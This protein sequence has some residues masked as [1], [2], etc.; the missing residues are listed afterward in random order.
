MK[1]KLIKYSPYVLNLILIIMMGYF[2]F[3]D[4]NNINYEGLTYFKLY[5]V[6]YGKFVLVGLYLVLVVLLEVFKKKQISTLHFI[7]NLSLIFIFI[8]A[9]FRLNN[10]LYLALFELLIPIVLLWLHT[11][12]IKSWW[13]LSKTAHVLEKVSKKLTKNFVLNITSTHVIILKFIKIKITRRRREYFLGF[14]FIG[15][16]IIGMLVFTLYPLINSIY[17]S[18]TKS[19]YNINEGVT[20]TFVGFTN[21]VNIFRNQTLMPK[22]TS[23]IG[24]ILLAVP[25]IIIFS[26][27]IAMLINQPIKGKGIAR[28]IFFL[29]VIIS[30]GPILAELTHQNATSLPSIE[31]S[32]ALNFIVSN[33]GKWISDPI[34]MLMSSLLLVL[35]YAGVPILIFLAGLQKTDRSIYEAS[36]IDGASPW[37]RFWKITLPSIKPLITVSIIYI[38]VSMSLYVDADSVLTEARSHM[39]GD[40][41]WSHGYGYAAA[42]SWVYF[43]L[44][45]IIMLLF[46]GIINVRRKRVK[47]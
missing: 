18:F 32:N 36:A 13:Y 1:D 19:Y 47:S 27:I 24:K 6:Y 43:L 46:I 29:P 9:W 12:Q 38:I 26:L 21:Y 16:W 20:G 28:T 34:E 44:M 23:Y 15:L 40:A 3:Y 7:Y 5:T 4:F 22:F 25:L 33:L 11:S 31:D 14:L 35:W 45:V 2:A 41:T 42:I 17:L 37:D 39:L 8:M 30:S 10:K